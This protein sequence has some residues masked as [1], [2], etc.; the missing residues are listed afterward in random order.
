[1]YNA[2]PVLLDG[3]DIHSLSCNKKLPVHNKFDLH[4]LQ[5]TERAYEGNNA[6]LHHAV[7]NAQKIEIRGRYL[8][9]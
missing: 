3:R 1:M 5:P 6:W 2:F 7:L 4:V 9:N 8:E